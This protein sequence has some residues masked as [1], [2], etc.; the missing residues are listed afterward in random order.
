MGALPGVELEIAEWIHEAQK[1]EFVVNLVP[2]D[3]IAA[4]SPDYLSAK[5]NGEL[6]LVQESPL[7][8]AGPVDE[9]SLQRFWEKAFVVKTCFASG[10]TALAFDDRLGER[11][12]MFA[13]AVMMQRGLTFKK[14]RSEA[15]RIGL[16]VSD[17]ERI[18]ILKQEK[19]LPKALRVDRS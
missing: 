5:A 10:D 3:E 2:E 11:T 8:S 13:I 18:A 12:A 17:P 14:A 9:K 7:P 1:H 15:S 4:V 16:S 6:P 19:G